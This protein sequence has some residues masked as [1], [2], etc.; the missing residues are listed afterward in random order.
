M[1]INIRFHG[2]AGS[3]SLRAYVCRRIDFQ[4]RRLGTALSAVVVRLSDVNGPKGGNDKRC[5]VIIRRS[6]LRP[7]AVE[8]LRADAYAAIDV[9]V[10]R[11]AHAAARGL[12]RARSKRRHTG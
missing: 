10:E 11:A 9:A 5:Q 2:L 8:E 1:T 7:I 4:L 12:K 3:D 6:G